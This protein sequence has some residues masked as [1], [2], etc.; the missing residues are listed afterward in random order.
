M[1][2]VYKNYES[3]YKSAVGNWLFKKIFG[4]IL[5][6]FANPKVNLAYACVAM[7][8]NCWVM[9]YGFLISPLYILIDII[10][11]W[12]RW[13]QVCA[14]SH[15]VSIPTKLCQTLRI[16]AS[17]FALR[18]LGNAFSATFRHCRFQM[19]KK[20]KLRT[21][22]RIFAIINF[23]PKMFLINI[24]GIWIP[25][26]WLPETFEYRTCRSLDFKWFGIQMVGPRAMY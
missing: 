22:M 12:I 20:L 21:M 1:F 8:V 17:A 23:F 18:N 16:F 4:F 6:R 25:T 14:K 10:K 13:R 5:N 11:L 9:A 2:T 26:I 7:M 15:I 19:P 3:K 24:M